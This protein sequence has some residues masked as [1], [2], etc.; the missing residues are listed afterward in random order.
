MNGYYP[1]I[2]PE[3]SSEIGLKKEQMVHKHK[4]VSPFMAYYGLPMAN[5][6][7]YGPFNYP[8]KWWNSSFSNVYGDAD[9]S[10]NPNMQVGNPAH[11][12]AW[13]KGFT[14][15]GPSYLS[16]WNANFFTYTSDAM[17]R[18]EKLFGLNS[19]GAYSLIDVT[20]CPNRDEGNKICKSSGNSNGIPYLENM[21]LVG[22]ENRP[23][24]I[25]WLAC[26][27]DNK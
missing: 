7:R 10:Q 13:G 15:Y 12:T 6:L 3:G 27:K 14:Y 20:V 19:S 21:P 22:N 1:R 24:S 23:K 4:H 2:A 18:T 5:Q 25:V 16:S 26:E 8:I 9:Y 17:N 11:P